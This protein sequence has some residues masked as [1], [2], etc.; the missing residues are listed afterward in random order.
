MPLISERGCNNSN[1][2]NSAQLQHP[3]KRKRKRRRSLF[4]YW[5]K[6]ITKYLDQSAL[7]GSFY[8]ERRGSLIANF[9]TYLF[10]VTD[11]S[12]EREP[13]YRFLGNHT[14]SDYFKLL[15]KEAN[16]LLIGAR[17]M[18]YNLSLPTLEENLDRVSF[19]RNYL[20]GY[21]T[22]DQGRR[23]SKR[24][25]SYGGGSRGVWNNGAILSMIV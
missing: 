13:I 21:I 15:K 22:Q 14:H 7:D 9:L 3:Y 23:A 4:S 6:H 12:K 8:R 1:K 25:Q 20:Y 5:T 18:V 2:G 11:A 24:V 17:N 16:S 10:F 19:F